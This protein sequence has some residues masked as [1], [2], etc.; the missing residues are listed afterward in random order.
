MTI[1]IASAPVLTIVPSPP[2]EWPEGVAAPAGRWEPAGGNV[3][4]PTLAG[5]YPRTTHDLTWICPTRA[6]LADLEAF[7]TARRGPLGAWWLPVVRRDVRRSAVTDNGDG[8]ATWTV[9]A[10]GY[11]GA[12]FPDLTQRAV[13]AF[14]A[15]GA[16]ASRREAFQV[17]AAVDNGD[18]TETW[19]VAAAG[20]EGTGTVPTDAF[21]ALLEPVR[22]SDDGWSVEYP[23]G[24]VAVV[25]ASAV[26]VTEELT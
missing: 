14:G 17:T 26:T 10:S 13:L 1:T 15:G 23:T 22:L 24:S 6:A 11:A 21:I 8:T 7:F 5:R 19:T 25:R 4:T 16:L 12:V 18:G 9:A 20:T 2:E 3:V